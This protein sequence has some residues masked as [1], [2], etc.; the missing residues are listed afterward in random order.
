MKHLLRTR[1][2]K[3]IVT[4]F[5]VPSR[6]SRKVIILCGGMPSIPCKDRIIEFFAKK[7]YWAFYPRYRGTWE[8]AGTFLAKS[9]EQD[10]LDI[11]DQLPKGFTSIWEKRDFKLQPDKL[12]V[13]GISFGGPAAILTSRDPRVTKSISIAGVTD[14]RAESKIEPMHLLE[15]IVREGYGGAY[16]FS[17]RRW[18]QLSKGAF[19]NPIDQANSIN[20]EKLFL[21]HAKDDDLVPYRSVKQFSRI[22]KTHLWTFN[23]GGHLSSAI[24]MRPSIYKKISKFL[25]S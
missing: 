13:I 4:E 1:F 18:Q 6:P 11:I 24:L 2:A 9:P 15:K 22:T 25:K 10:I 20:P 12:F 7:G 5:A 17:H 19:Y 14:W 16:R 21:L 3:D 8:S 23:R